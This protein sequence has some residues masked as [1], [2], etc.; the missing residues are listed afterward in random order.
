MLHE[1]TGVKAVMPAK[2]GIQC[3]RHDEVFYCWHYNFLIRHRCV[4]RLACCESGSSAE[5]VM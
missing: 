3:A 4:F 2:A 5:P 1:G